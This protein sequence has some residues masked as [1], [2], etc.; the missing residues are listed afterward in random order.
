MQMISEIM[1]PDVVTFGQDDSMQ[2]AAQLMD[3]LE[4][5]SIPV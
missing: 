4:V 3:E 2:R 5:G 1:T